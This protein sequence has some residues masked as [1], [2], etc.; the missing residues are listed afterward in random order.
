MLNRLSDVYIDGY[1]NGAFEVPI[2][3]Q[4]FGE[5]VQVAASRNRVLST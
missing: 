5:P 3:E 2:A 4:I 1:V